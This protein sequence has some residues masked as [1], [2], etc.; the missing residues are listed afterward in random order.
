MQP[1]VSQYAIDKE[2]RKDNASLIYRS[3]LLFCEKDLGAKP[4][5]VH[6]LDD[7]VENSNYES[8]NCAINLVRNEIKK[9]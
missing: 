7:Y 4:H 3:F 2:E 8:K 1:Q 5:L 6:L 9:K